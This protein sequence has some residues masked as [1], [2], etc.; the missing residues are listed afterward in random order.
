MYIQRVHGNYIAKKKLSTERDLQMEVWL[1]GDVDDHSGF[2][3][4]KVGLV[5]TNIN[6]ES[7]WH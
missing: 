6:A 1:A 3:T 7:C 2:A 4:F 5:A